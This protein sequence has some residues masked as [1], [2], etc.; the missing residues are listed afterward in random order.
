MTVDADERDLVLLARDGDV[1]AFSTLVER[2]WFPLVRFA[3]SILGETD[4]EDSVQDALVAAWAKISGLKHPEA[5]TAWLLRI[6]ARRSFRRARR[7]TRQVPLTEADG[8]PDPAAE[9]ATATVDVERIL[10]RLA[11]RQRAVMHLT[12]IDG[13]TDSEIAAALGITA[14]SVRSHRRRAREALHSVLMPFDGRGA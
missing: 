4:A 2:H 9:S 5:F 6:V 12:V 10:S 1:G 14:A 3:R 8:A 7:G 13:M 11:P